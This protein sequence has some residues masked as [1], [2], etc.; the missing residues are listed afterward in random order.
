MTVCNLMSDKTSFHPVA[1]IALCLMVSVEINAGE[2]AAGQANTHTENDVLSRLIVHHYFPESRI[3]FES[4][5]G[6]GVD[7]NLTAGGCD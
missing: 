6:T 3:H 5:P 1:L 4:T 2:S 7:E